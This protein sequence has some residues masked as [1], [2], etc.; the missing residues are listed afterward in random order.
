MKSFFQL[1]NDQE[2][3]KKRIVIAFEDMNPPN[4]YHAKLIEKVKTIAEKQDADH[5]IFVS[6]VRDCKLNPLSIQEKIKYFKN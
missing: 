4:A 2:Q 3:L 1:V 5:S 6:G